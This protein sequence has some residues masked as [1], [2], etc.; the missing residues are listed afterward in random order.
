MKSPHGESFSSTSPGKQSNAAQPLPENAQD[1][2]CCTNGMIQS[3]SIA[4]F[5]CSLLF[6]L[7]GRKRLA[8]RK[9][10]EVVRMAFAVERGNNRED[11]GQTMGSPSFPSASLSFPH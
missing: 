8:G 11:K 3:F 4:G 1:A 7:V 6:S 5:V 10:A 2:A 9:E